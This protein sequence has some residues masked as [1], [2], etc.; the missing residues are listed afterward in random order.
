MPDRF[1][2]LVQHP[3]QSRPTAAEATDKDDEETHAF[4]HHT[5][6]L[7]YRGQ[8]PRGRT[9]PWVYC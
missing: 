1:R 6:P 3:N 4:Y 8:T 9:L 5:H 7:G 2:D